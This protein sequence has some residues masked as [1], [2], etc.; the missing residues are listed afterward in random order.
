MVESDFL[1]RTIRIA[2]YVQL[3]ISTFSS[4][5]WK[6]TGHVGVVQN[7]RPSF[8]NSRHDMSCKLQH[9]AMRARANYY[10]HQREKKSPSFAFVIH[11]SCME[12]EVFNVSQMLMFMSKHRLDKRVDFDGI[13]SIHQLP[14]SA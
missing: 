13:M 8:D 2:S 6:Q 4:A 3:V 12:N 7:L 14:M 11:V 1:S 10:Q 5:R 9:S